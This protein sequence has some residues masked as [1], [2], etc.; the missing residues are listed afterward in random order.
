MENSFRRS[1]NLDG[2]FVVDQS[3]V[4]L[5]PVFLIDDAVDSGWTFTVVTALL[6][7]ANAGKVYPVALTSTSNQG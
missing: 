2:A 4:Y 1:E 6:K 7:K 5:D 3:Q